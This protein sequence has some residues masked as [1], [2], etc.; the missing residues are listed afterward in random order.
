MTHEGDPREGER[1]GVGVAVRWQR[2]ATH[3][4][5]GEE[6]DEAVE[7]LA[8]LGQ[9]HQLT[10]VLQEEQGTQMA[11]VNARSHASQHRTQAKNQ[12]RTVA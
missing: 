12:T 3:K 11:N 4:Y 6:V 9:L 8:R 5:L 1:L 10:Q 2:S 7:A